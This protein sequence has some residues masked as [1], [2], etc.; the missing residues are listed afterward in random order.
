MMFRSFAAALA[1]LCVS[2]SVSGF[3]S[4][5][6]KAPST[7]AMTKTSTS[8]DMWSEE[9]MKKATTS[10]VA[11]T[12]LVGNIAT[13]IAPA[14]AMNDPADAFGGSSQLIAARSGGRAGGRSAAARAAPRSAPR[15]SS[16]TNTRIIDRTTYV[17]PPVYSSPS[18]IMAP[19]VYNPVPGL[20][21]GLGLNAINQIG[22]DM[23]DYRQESEIRDT[24]SQLEQSKMR[25]AEL[26]ARLRQL[27]MQGQNQMSQQQ[28]LLQQQMM[29]QQQAAV[30]K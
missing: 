7:D 3:A 12:L 6:G 20:G 11:A 28:I 17:A 19:P 2:E 26:E 30:A 8:L 18:I 9:G 21:L 5:H 1:L 22:N 15:P 29:Q 10:L 13:G 27:E 14:V 25:E 24:R 4:L 23:R 16:T